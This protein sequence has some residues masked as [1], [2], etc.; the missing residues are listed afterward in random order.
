MDLSH[1][2]LNFFIEVQ[3]KFTYKRKPEGFEKLG[4]SRISMPIGENFTYLGDVNKLLIL[5]YINRCY[6]L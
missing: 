5:S 1:H 6:N 4:K 2:F 3:Q